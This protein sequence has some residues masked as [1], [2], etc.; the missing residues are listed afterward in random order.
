MSEKRAKVLENVGYAVGF[1]EELINPLWSAYYCGPNTPSENGP[2][3][4]KFRADTRV[5]VASRLKHED[6]N[7]PRGVTPTYDRGHMAPNYAIATRYGREAQL[8]TFLMTNI[9]PQRSSLNQKTWK[10][11]EA[12][13][14]R[15]FAV[16]N[17]GVWVIV[18]PIFDGPLTRYNAKA[19]M[20]SAFYCIVLDRTEDGDLRALALTMDQSVTGTRRLGD[21]ITTVNAI[22][23]STGLN[24]FSE[25]PDDVEERL[26]TAKADA[27]WNWDLMLDPNA[28]ADGD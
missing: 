26:E 9:V 4:S 13:I 19:A 5:P 16:R 1:S 3:P 23:K 10:A 18:G 14:A 11:L 21:F 28:S 17:E 6:Y 7:R 12:A 2:R 27:D 24:F 25:L 22:E 15:N 20:P 8:E